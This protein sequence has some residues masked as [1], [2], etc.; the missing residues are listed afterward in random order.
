MCCRELDQVRTEL[1]PQSIYLPFKI[2]RYKDHYSCSICLKLRSET[3]FDDKQTRAK[4]EKGYAESCYRFCFRCGIEEGLYGN[5][6]SIVIGNIRYYPCDICH[7]IVRK[8][9]CTQCRSCR[10]CFKK[11]MA[12]QKSRSKGIYYSKCGGCDA[13]FIHLRRGRW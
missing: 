8:L 5:R 12:R 7:Q 1:S 6:K 2:F 13:P 11:R 3:V 4:C 9:L 10:S